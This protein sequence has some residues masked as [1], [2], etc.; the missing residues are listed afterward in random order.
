M[1]RVW[2]KEA[3]VG[4]CHTL[5]PHINS[6]FVLEIDA[7][8]LLSFAVA[9]A[10][11]TRYMLKVAGVGVADQ[12]L[13]FLRINLVGLQESLESLKEVNKEVSTV[14]LNDAAV[15][16][17]MFL[18][19]LIEVQHMELHRCDLS[20]L[21]AMVLQSCILGACHSVTSLEMNCTEHDFDVE[22]AVLALQSAIH[23]HPSLNSVRLHDVQQQTL[24]NIIPNTGY[25]P[26]LEGL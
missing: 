4:T 17:G 2:L 22:E 6:N 7:L 25:Y 11:Q 8:D 12:S 5:L 9:E 14:S 16:L 20:D 3:R 1:G 13:D 19:R 21:S 26:Q 23:K 18:G 10:R 24:E 15:S